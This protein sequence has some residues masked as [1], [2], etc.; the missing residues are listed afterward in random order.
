MES[1]YTFTVFTATYNRAST[2][3]RVY[4]SLVA[5]SFQDFEWLIGDDG[6]EDETELLVQS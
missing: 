4:N 2:L 5:Q 3:K 1:K 6:S